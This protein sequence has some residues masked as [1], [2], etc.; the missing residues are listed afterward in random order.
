MAKNRLRPGR[1][2]LAMGMIIGTVMVLDNL[3]QDLFGTN[4]KLV[5]S[6]NF[7]S[8][9]A[10]YV[11]VP[12]ESQ[13]V[14]GNEAQTATSFTGVQNLGFTEL[15][16]P[17]SR[18]SAGALV[19]VDDKSAAGEVSASGKVSLI[20]KK[21]EFYTLLNDNLM[22]DQ[23]AADA[24][25]LMMADYYEAT[26]LS[27]FIVYGTTDTYTGDGSLC[28]RYFPESAMG[29]T[30]DLALNGYGSALTFDGYDEQGWVLDNC[31]KYGFIVR[32]P[33]GKKDK[34]SYEFCPWHLRYVGGVHAAIMDEKEF[35][36]E[37]YLDFLKNYTFDNAFT[38]NLNGV[39]Y[40]IYSVASQGDSTPVRVP[41]SGDYT[42][43]GNNSDR[44]IITAVKKLLS[45]RSK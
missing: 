13:R 21:N 24:L 2:V 26:A 23:E 22:L 29:N 10:Q 30:I 28:P 32:Y 16:L 1:V 34:T 11:E 31:A 14:L 40:E 44:Y 17:S 7:K 15:N 20:K 43:S 45:Y 5:V 39:N 8:G 38:Y 33:Q 4:T 25:N 37:E 41:V 12:T 18:L 27:D 9:S 6:G 19:L 35:C 42:I 36:L 3:K